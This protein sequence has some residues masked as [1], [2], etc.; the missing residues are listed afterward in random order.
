MRDQIEFFMNLE[1]EEKTNN[2]R[3]EWTFSL[4]GGKRWCE[5][6]HKLISPKTTAN[7][8]ITTS[9][10]HR[11][12]AECQSTKLFRLFFFGKG[13]EKWNNDFLQQKGEGEATTEAIHQ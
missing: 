7:V 12:K 11:T 9:K 6:E 2:N 8:I 3:T 4:Q 10:N 13:A 1:E 5:C